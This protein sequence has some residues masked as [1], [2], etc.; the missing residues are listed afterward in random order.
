MKAAELRQKTR[1]DLETLLQATYQRV[2]DLRF[3]LAQ[4]KS[5]NVKEIATARKEIARIKTILH[6]M[7][8]GGA[9][10]NQ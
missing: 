1:D 8:V 6:A 9:A 2:G 3:K 10:G 4:K 7:A 5:K